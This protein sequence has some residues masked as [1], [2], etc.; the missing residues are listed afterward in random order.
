M[1]MNRDEIMAPIQDTENDL[2]RNILWNLS[3]S[4]YDFR[5][6]KPTIGW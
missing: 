6:A 1:P 2:Q 5:L 3:G 4:S